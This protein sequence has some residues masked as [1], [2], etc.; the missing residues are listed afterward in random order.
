VHQNPRQETIG[1]QHE[2]VTW[3]KTTVL[4]RVVAHVEIKERTTTVKNHVV[5]IFF[6]SPL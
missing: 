1:A 3:L 6:Q 2:T 4:P 5:L